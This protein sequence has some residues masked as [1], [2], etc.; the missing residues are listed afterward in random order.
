MSKLTKLREKHPEFVYESFSWNLKGGDLNVEFSF[1]LKPDIIFKPS[2]TFENIDAARF[3]SLDKAL[4]DN[5]LFHIGMIESFSYWKSAASRKIV[6]ESGALSEDQIKWWKSLL[7]KGMGQFFYENEIDFKQKDFV[8]IISKGEKQRRNP[9]AVHSG[10]LTG[11]MVAIGGG[12]DSAVTAEI[13]GSGKKK[14]SAFVVNPTKASL[15]TIEKSGIDKTIIV[16]RQLDKKLL[17]LNKKGHLNGHTP[18]SALLAFISVFTAWLYDY[19]NVVFS[20]ESSS[21]ESNVRYLGEAVNHQYSKTSEFEN[22]FRG[23]IKKHLDVGVDYFSF[24]RPLYEIQISKIFAKL[25]KYFTAIK[26]CNKGSKTNSW[27]CECPKCLSTFILLYPFLKE[28]DILRI[29][30]TNMYEDIL[31]KTLLLSL[32]EENKVKP[33][34]CVGTREEITIALYLSIKE[35]G[36]NKLSKLLKFANEVVIDKQ[37]N[38]D[39]RAQRIF[40]H[41]ANNNLQTSFKSVLKNNL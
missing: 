2:L 32:V 24:L 15:D 23:Y 16:R 35:A 38:L 22:T 31:L 9:V 39:K 20:N 34:E 13:M 12:I 29:F 41:W 25:D 10:N 18:F 27:C 7:L 5:F 40:D 36:D 37:K 4:L 33:F 19:K 1:K 8:Q 26:S 21:D 11:T 6:V 28:K 3:A 17:E 14:V 30:P